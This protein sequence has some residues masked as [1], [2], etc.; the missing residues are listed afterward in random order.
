M[1]ANLLNCELC[2]KGYACV[3]EEKQADKNEETQANKNARSV[4]FH[5][6]V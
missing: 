6:D 5:Q 2:N 1:Y 4:G 3:I